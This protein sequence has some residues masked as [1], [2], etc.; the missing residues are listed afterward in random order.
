MIAN[1]S[2]L[3]V[4]NKD[5]CMLVATATTGKIAQGKNK[6][7]KNLRPIPSP[8]LCPD[9]SAAFPWIAE[10]C[11]R[12]RYAIG[13]P[14]AGPSNAAC[15]WARQGK[16]AAGAAV[17][18]AIRHLDRAR[19]SKKK[20]YL[21]SGLSKGIITLDA[22]AHEAWQT[23]DDARAAKNLI[24]REWEGITGQRPQGADYDSS[25]RGCHFTMGVDFQG[26]PTAEVRLIYR[27]LEHAIARMLYSRGYR[28]QDVNIEIKGS[29]AQI[30]PDLS[31]MVSGSLTQIPVRPGYEAALQSLISA[32]DVSGYEVEYVAAALE[33]RYPAVPAQ[34]ATAT[35]AVATADQRTPD[36]NGQFA[37]PEWMGP[38]PTVAQPT[39]I[40]AVAQPI[41]AAAPTQ[42]QSGAGPSPIG[43]GPGPVSSPG[44]SNSGWE[45]NSFNRQREALLRYSRQLRRVPSVDEAMQHI[46]DHGLFSGDWTD[47]LGKR[48]SRVSRILDYLARTFDPSKAQG[49]VGGNGICDSEFLRQLKRSKN[50]FPTQFY[51]GRVLVSAQDVAV[52][53]YLAWYK[54]VYAPNVDKT[55]P[56]E[57]HKALWNK[58]HEEKKVRTRFNKK[59]WQYIRQAMESAKEINVFD[60][61]YG[62]GEAMKWRLDSQ[63][64]HAGQGM[65]HKAKPVLSATQRVARDCYAREVSEEFSSAAAEEARKKREEHNLLK[66][67]PNSSNSLDQ[68]ENGLTEQDRAPPPPN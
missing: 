17:R 61:N 67:N 4:P 13:S 43:V 16:L 22:D 29:P 24:L 64:H 50:Q 49:L 25:K 45:P 23:L 18:L 63:F 57:S 48:R 20:F 3:C 32:P 28:H 26:R 40:P 54:I 59:R 41:G 6:K 65:S 56:R 31:N 27:R 51:L 55:V 42:P 10:H 58:M 19:A 12:Y 5:E 38:P 62:R 35:P 11:D 52:M 39:A 2:K 9:I 37:P 8:P 1:P 36:S 33:S 60:P 15:L 44:Q 7:P 53:R 68:A 34:Q 30:E 46:R 21:C 14:A 66:G 47:N